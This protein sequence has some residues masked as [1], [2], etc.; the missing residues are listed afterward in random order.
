[1]PLELRSI[2]EKALEKDPSDRYQST[3]DLVV[4]LKRVSRLRAP[5][6]TQLGAGEPKSKRRWR[7]VL[8]SLAA[9]LIVQA[10]ALWVL[11]QSDF[12]WTNPLANAQF[13]RLTDFE[14]SEMDA[15][16]SP[17]GKATKH[18]PAVIE[19]HNLRRARRDFLNQPRPVAAALLAK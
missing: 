16:I 11:L 13:T 7:L 10:A 4:D 8:A 5:E 15:A 19:T 2:V 1:M 14:G 6:P 18:M 12:F 17:D 3:R 9:V